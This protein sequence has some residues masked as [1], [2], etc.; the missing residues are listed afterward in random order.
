VPGG[1]PEQ[2][3]EDIQPWPG[4]SALHHSDLLSQGEIPQQ[5]TTAGAKETG[6]R[7]QTEPTDGEHRSDIP[8]G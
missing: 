5:E 4:M 7:A 3:I 1:N 6:K 2:F 8:K